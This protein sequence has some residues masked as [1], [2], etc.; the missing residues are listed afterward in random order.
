L[1]PLE[2]RGGAALESLDSALKLAYVREATAHVEHALGALRLSTG[3]IVRAERQ[4]GLRQLTN[5]SFEMFTTS[6]LLRDPGPDATTLSANA[7]GP[8]IRVF[9]VPDLSVGSPER[10]VQNVRLSNSDYTTWEI[11]AARRFT[12]RWSLDASLA[13]T[14]HHDHASA[15]L[16]QTVRANA[17]AVTPNDLI[18][19]D[20]G[21]RHVFR[22]WVAKAHGTWLGPWRL[23]I[24]PLVRHQSGQPFARTVLA[25]LNVGTIRVLA[26][27]IGTR[28][29]DNVTL[30]DLSARRDFALREGRRA[31]VFV[32][33]FNLFNANPEQTVTWASGPSFLRP[34]SIV[35]P[36]IARIGM[37]LDW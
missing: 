16:G 24:S 5:R 27:P 30:V 29:Q 9:D 6:T 36:R 11:A 1:L 34:L 7:D 3:V 26:E 23:R 17:Y 25:R 13:H 20:E 2:R 12:A 8:E 33:A 37:R 31:S 21:G 32:E 28:R 15:Y 19:T 14:W 4:Q 10:V 18:N 35:P 22:T